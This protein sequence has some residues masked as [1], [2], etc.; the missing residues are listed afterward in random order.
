MNEYSIIKQLFKYFAYYDYK[1]QN[2]FIFDWESDFFGVSKVGYTIEVEVKITKADFKADFKKSQKHFILSNADKE[3]ITLP[4]QFSHREFTIKPFAPNQFFY[5]CP[6][7]LIDVKDIPDY[8]GLLYLKEEQKNDFEGNPMNPYE[9]IAKVKSAKYIH[10]NKPDISKIL[11]DKFYYNYLN[12]KHEYNM[13]LHRVNQ[14]EQRFDFDQTPLNQKYLDD[15]KIFE[16]TLFS[17]PK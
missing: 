11:L 8:A 2:V 7:G 10:K 15:Q 5:C 6:E 14:I 12:I 9:T 16:P 1:L 17:E 13:L 4:H 3:S